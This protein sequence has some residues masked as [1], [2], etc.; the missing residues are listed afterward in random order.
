MKKKIPLKPTKTEIVSSIIYVIAKIIVWFF[1]LA[2]LSHLVAYYIYN[3][4]KHGLFDAESI[5]ICVY[6]IM[7]SYLF[8]FIHRDQVKKIFKVR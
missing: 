3:I 8:L 2:A 4:I 5:K 7:G 1:L 6:L